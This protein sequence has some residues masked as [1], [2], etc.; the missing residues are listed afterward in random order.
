M[1]PPCRSF[2][3]SAFLLGVVPAALYRH[4]ANKNDLVD[5]MVDAVLRAPPRS[6]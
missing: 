1:I 3:H 4:V 5:A 6:C 2:D